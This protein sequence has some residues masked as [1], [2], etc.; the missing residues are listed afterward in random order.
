MTLY[1]KHYNSFIAFILLLFCPLSSA[2]ARSGGAG[3]HSSAHSAAHS[4]HSSKSYSSYDGYTKSSK[5]KSK[6]HSRYLTA[7]AA[8]VSA[9]AYHNNSAYPDTGAGSSSAANSSSNDNSNTGYN[10]SYTAATTDET[11]TATN[12]DDHD[13]LAVIGVCI[14]ILAIYGYKWKKGREPKAPVIA[15]QS[16]YQMPA[17]GTPFPD[18]LEL[19]KVSRSFLAIQDAWQRKDLRNVRKWLSDGMYQ[20]FT[21]QFKMMN[22]L[23]QVNTLSN[24]QI[25]NIEVNDLQ[26]DG[27]YQIAE[28]AIS[29]IMD[30]K[31]I[32]KKYPQLNET[33]P[34]DVNTEYWTFIKHTGGKEQNIYDNNVCPNCGATLGSDAGEINRCSNCNTLINNATYDWVLCE[35]TQDSEYSGGMSLSNDIMLKQLMQQDPAFAVQRLEDIASNIFMQI[36][37]IFTGSD[38]KRLSRFADDSIVKLI[39]QQKHSTKPFIFDRLFLNSVTLTGYSVED[40]LV[41]LY[42]DIYATYRR[43][44]VNGRV[45]L[46]DNNLITVQ[47]RMEL[48][49]SKDFSA[50]SNETVYSYE[51][52]SCGAPFTDTTADCCTYCGAPVIDK[53]RDWVLTG[54]VLYNT[55]NAPSSEVDFL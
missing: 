23:D 16:N 52:S 3:G 49:R 28:I 44:A 51:C 18:G 32:S 42:F 1:H 43:V 11:T 36:M 7:G 34:S 21:A 5:H 41:K 33:Y 45:Q 29:F 2:F 6:S 27:N 22:A 38:E 9:N 25:R 40:N 13:T 19:E 15:P 24:I 31:F 20:R 48:S 8:Y 30:D 39:L 10:S 47:Y 54:F 26:S 55:V 12:S 14:L 46:I 53:K 37:E 4:Y 50:K 35:I 17:G